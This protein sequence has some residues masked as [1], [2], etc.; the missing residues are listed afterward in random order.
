MIVPGNNKGGQDRCKGEN[1]ADC[2]RFDSWKQYRQIRDQH[3]INRKG[4]FTRIIVAQERV[5]GV[6]RN[7][8]TA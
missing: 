6:L 7:Q 2:K 8:G 5:F 3:N 4:Q 1:M